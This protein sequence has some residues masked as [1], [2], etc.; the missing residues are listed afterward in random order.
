MQYVMQMSYANNL[1]SVTARAT[2]DRESDSQQVCGV[3]IL[4]YI[5]TPFAGM[6]QGK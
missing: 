3:Y 5:L 4:R 6:A 2:E 1:L